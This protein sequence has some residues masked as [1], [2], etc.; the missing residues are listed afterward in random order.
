MS[1]K[2]SRQV[3]PPDKV[4]LYEKL[5]SATPGVERKTGFG[6]PYTA[7]NGN[8]YSMM[9]KDGSLALRLGK[10]DREAFLEKFSTTLFPGPIGPLKEY[11]LVPDDLLKNTR[12]LKKY[13]ALSFEYAKT[14]RPKAQKSSSKSPSKKR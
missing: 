7:I 11:V 4:A 2:Q 13:M 3:T 1:T 6:S 14:L 5:I 9:A 10:Q 8:M 12:V